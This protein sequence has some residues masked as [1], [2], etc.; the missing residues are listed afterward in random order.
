MVGE[1]Q[2]R[3][4]AF[5][6]AIRLTS[7]YGPSLGPR[8]PTIAAGTMADVAVYRVMLGPFADARQAQSVCNSLRSGGYAC[9]AQ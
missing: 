6:L 2:S 8:K 9:I 5:A 7:Q 3:S 4:E 1:S